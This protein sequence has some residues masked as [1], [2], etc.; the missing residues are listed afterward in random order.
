MK[1][2]LMVTITCPDRPGIV[3][4][5]TQVVVRYSAN[6]EDSR[7]ARLGG[8]FAGIVMISVAHEDVEALKHAL[9]DLCSEETTIAVKITRAD[10]P[11]VRT[12][13]AMYEL[14]LT[15]A[16]HEGIV[17]KLSAYLAAQGINVE[18]METKVTRAPMSAAPLFSMDAVVKVPPELSLAELDESLQRIGESLGVDIDIR[19]AQP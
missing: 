8:D 11:A 1:T 14:H 17:H 3:E 5:I 7:L 13:H 4:Q 10:D 6:W 12:L 9:L 18:A 16:D 2:L 15:G 19:A